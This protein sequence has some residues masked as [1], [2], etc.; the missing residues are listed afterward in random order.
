MISNATNSVVKVMLNLINYVKLLQFLLKTKKVRVHKYGNRLL[1]NILLA[2]VTFRAVSD[3]FKMLF[4]L[5]FFFS[6]IMGNLKR[7]Q[8][9]FTSKYYSLLE[10]NPLCKLYSLLFKIIITYSY[11]FTILKK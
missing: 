9:N 1:Y 11:F 5:L 3:V 6:K 8:K 7:T 2:A 4:F 10:F